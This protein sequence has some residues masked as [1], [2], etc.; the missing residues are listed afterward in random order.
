[1]NRGRKAGGRCH[2]VGS[3]R[4]R[5][6]IRRIASRDFGTRDWRRPTTLP[7]AGNS[8]CLHGTPSGARIPNI[9]GF[10]SNRQHRLQPVPSAKH[11]VQRD[12]HQR[13]DRRAR[14]ETPHGVDARILDV[15]PVEPGDRRRPHSASDVGHAY[16]MS[17]AGCSR[18]LPGPGRSPR[19]SPECGCS[20][21]I[22]RRHVR[23][24]CAPSSRQ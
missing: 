9:R 14:Q 2:E 24:D 11:P 20:H 23:R 8:T 1:V 17:A 10:S 6:R 15:L 19:D 16:I 13:D 4:S 22:W 3:R 7:T 21:P 12:H 5:R 18:R